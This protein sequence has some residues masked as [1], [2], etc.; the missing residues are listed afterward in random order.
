MINI[1]TIVIFCIK[2]KQLIQLLCI[3]S[4][5]FSMFL[6]VNFINKIPKSIPINAFNAF[7]NEISN[8]IDIPIDIKY[9][10]SINISIIAKIIVITF[11]LSILIL[12]YIYI[13]S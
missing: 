11:L 7:Q 4:K 12:L 10:P 13:F 9:K 8:N 2:E 5:I 6:P 1:E 3:S